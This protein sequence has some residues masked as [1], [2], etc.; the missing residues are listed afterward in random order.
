MKSLANI[1]TTGLLAA[2]MLGI[3]TA[4][5]ANAASEEQ[6]AQQKIAEQYNYEIVHEINTTDI[7]KINGEPCTYEEWIEYLNW[8]QNLPD[9][10][11]EIVIPGDDEEG[12]VPQPETN[13]KIKGL[14]HASSENCMELM[15]TEGT[16]F[17]WLYVY[18]MSNTVKEIG[19]GC[20]S[21][22]ILCDKTG[23]PLPGIPFISEDCLNLSC[24]YRD[25][26]VE[27]PDY[28]QYIVDC[29]GRSVPGNFNGLG[30]WSGDIT[31]AA[32]VG[33]YVL[34]NARIEIVNPLTKTW[35]KQMYQII[36]SYEW[37]SK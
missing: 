8:I 18:N 26:E 6:Q 30:S 33:A 32:E 3:G 37:A 34:K 25:P 29:S 19:D 21:Q 9:G 11:I 23:N 5:V 15:L 35:N 12:P 2:T 7:Y 14:T 1:L 27:S 22:V 36:I 13:T 16:E 4:G 31:G 17:E 10:E 28:T 24:I 20:N